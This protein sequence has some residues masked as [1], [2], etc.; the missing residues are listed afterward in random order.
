MTS[1]ETTLFPM[2]R[3]LRDLRRQTIGTPSG[4]LTTAFENNE[5][6][7][8]CAESWLDPQFEPLVHLFHVKPNGGVRPIMILVERDWISQGSLFLPGCL[9]DKVEDGLGM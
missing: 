1:A 8:Y 5:E 6:L 4:R 9:L 3:H 2:Q 7:V